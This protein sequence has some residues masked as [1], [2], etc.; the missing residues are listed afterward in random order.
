MTEL[1]N[2]QLVDYFENNSVAYGDARC[3]SKEEI[4]AGAKGEA[5]KAEL[6]RRLG[7]AVSA[8]PQPPGC[9]ECGGTDL[10]WSNGRTVIFCYQGKPYPEHSFDVSTL[11]SFR[12]FFAPA[13]AQEPPKIEMKE[14]LAHVQ[15]FLNDLWAFSIDPL[16]EGM[17]GLKIAEVCAALLKAAKDNRDSVYELEGLFRTACLWVWKGL[18]A[19][20]Q[21][22]ESTME[23]MRKEYKAA[24]A[25]PVENSSRCRHCGLPIYFEGNYWLLV[26]PSTG[27]K[28][29][30]CATN[31]NG[32]HEAE[33]ISGRASMPLYSEQ[34]MKELG[35][36]ASTINYGAE[37]SATMYSDAPKSGA[38][39]GEQ[40]R[41]KLHD[42]PDET[43]V[44]YVMSGSWFFGY[45]G[46]KKQLRTEIISRINPARPSGPSAKLCDFPFQGDCT[47]KA[48]CLAAKEIAHREFCNNWSL[49][50]GVVLTPEQREAVF[51][52]SVYLLRK[53]LVGAPAQPGTEEKMHLNA[54][55]LRTIRQK[56]ADGEG[57]QYEAALLLQH[58]DSIPDEFYRAKWNE[59]QLEG[60]VSQQKQ[61]HSDTLELVNLCHDT[62][63]QDEP[64]PLTEYVEGHA[65]E[66]C[67]A[68]RV[69]EIAD[70][71]YHHRT[72]SPAQ[73]TPEPPTLQTPLPSEHPS[74]KRDDFPEWPQWTEALA[75]WV[76]GRVHAGEMS[77]GRLACV[78]D[79]VEFE[80]K[81][82]LA[83]PQNGQGW[84]RVDSG[85]LPVAHGVGL[86]EIDF[87]VESTDR[88]Y[89]GYY[90]PLF[91]EWHIAHT[92][93]RHG[94]ITAYDVTH[95]KESAAPPTGDAPTEKK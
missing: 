13:P 94:I 45:L 29:Q 38:S 7:A 87:Y 6:L 36:Q 26:R 17:E 46:D 56:I 9:P 75:Y 34:E 70:S 53:H 67:W 68:C 72:P 4:D 58:V 23:A 66:T 12:K 82:A 32:R 8:S 42:M 27:L 5:A 65:K 11:E 77:S 54:E 16:H 52:Y 79:V 74:P 25:Q 95:W 2:E 22:L 20:G 93:D 76:L 48:V 33:P 19:P 14:H 40:P 3:G 80:A 81:R 49:V 64:C 71:L 83:G 43:F 78:F 41:T 59:E 10:R 51:K 47:Q 50:T 21:T 37:G 86:A 89:H 62:F 1:T 90:D 85:K 28:Y 55:Q 84:V 39:T 91:K 24:P 61:A 88:L 44:N 69:G 73:G 18:D 63:P 15:Q 92:D 31:R 30:L 57:G 60:I 35:L